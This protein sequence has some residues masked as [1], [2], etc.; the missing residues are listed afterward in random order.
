MRVYRS[1]EAFQLTTTP[2]L[3]PR[4]AGILACGRH[5]CR[6]LDFLHFGRTTEGDHRSTTEPGGTGLQPVAGLSSSPVGHPLPPVLPSEAPGT[7]PG[8]LRA[9]STYPKVLTGAALSATVGR[10]LRPRRALS[11]ANLRTRRLPVS[12]VL[13]AKPLTAPAS[14]WRAGSLP[15][16]FHPSRSES[17]CPAQSARCRRHG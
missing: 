16:R 2:L 9:P 10:P 3:T 6:P 17:E 4:G 12:G 13:C 8:T 5:S 7:N 1:D 14:G 11:P 15:L